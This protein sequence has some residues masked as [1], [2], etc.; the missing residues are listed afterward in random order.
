MRLYI[1]GT[2]I[3]HLHLK[4]IKV[5]TLQ[6]GGFDPAYLYEVV[7]QAKDPKVMGVGLAAFRDVVF[8]FKFLLNPDLGAFP[9]NATPTGGLPR[10]SRRMAWSGVWMRL[11]R[12]PAPRAHRF[13]AW[14]VLHATLMCG[15]RRVAQ[16]ARRGLAR[17]APVCHLIRMRQKELRIALVCYGG[18]SLAVYMHGVT[19]E[20]W[21][22][23][24]VPLLARARALPTPQAEGQP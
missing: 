10:S 3:D 23:Q 7:Y 4:L 22:R 12:T 18:I 9:N 15:L 8:W 1:I 20:V 14:Q 5:T 17:W 2:T 13:L 6:G 21:Q 19:K 24:F 11:H 16:L